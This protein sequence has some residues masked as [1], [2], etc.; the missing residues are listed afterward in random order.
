MTSADESMSDVTAIIKT[1]ERPACLDRLI[2]SV[3][4]YYPRLRMIV[5]DDGFQPSPRDDVDYLR[6]PPDVGLSAGRNA[7]LDLVRTP[8]FLLLDDDLRFTD[9]TQIERLLVVARRSTGIIAGG[10]YLRCKRKFG[11]W[12]KRQRQSY[13]G[14]FER[15]GDQLTMHRSCYSQHD[16][17]YLC[18]IVHNFFVART[19]EVRAM[20]AWN[21]LL[22][23][24]EHEEF[25]LRAQQ[26]GLQVAYCPS[27]VA[28]HWNADVPRHYGRYRNRNF[29]PLALA[30]HGIRTFITPDGKS[31]AIPP[32]ETLTGSAGFITEHDHEQSSVRHRHAA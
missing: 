7:A 3:R 14:I 19:E 8:Y 18:D 1:F 30:L 25:F 17:H 9:A 29:L 21:P 12:V 27:V 23:L 13:H 4:R 11:L 24:H 2:R 6:L 10:T 5:A 26:A 28:E 15:S 22:K 20:G 32:L 31:V 16:D